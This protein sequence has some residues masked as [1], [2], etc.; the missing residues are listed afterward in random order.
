MVAAARAQRDRLW[1]STGRKTLARPSDLD[2]RPEWD[3][4]VGQLAGP[5]LGRPECRV[6]FFGITY[7]SSAVPARIR[8]ARDRCSSTGTAGAGGSATNPRTAPIPGTPAHGRHRR[9][10]RRKDP[11]RDRRLATPVQRRDRGRQRHPQQRHRHRR[12][13]SPDSPPPTPRP[14]SLSTNST[15]CAVRVR[16]AGPREGA[17]SWRLSAEIELAAVSLRV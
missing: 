5:R 12:R 10:G 11:D 16:G 3:H 13:R 1:M 14:P 8:Y 4:A 15:R 17:C 9:S 6:D 2:D 7:G